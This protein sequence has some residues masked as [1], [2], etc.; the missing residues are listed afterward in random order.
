MRPALP[1]DVVEHG[2]EPAGGGPPGWLRRAAAAVAATAV[3]FAVVRGGLLSADEPSPRPAPTP[4]RATMGT[5]EPQLVARRGDRLVVVRDGTVQRAT[6]L[7]AGLPAD[8]AL[9]TIAGAADAG[10]GPVVGVSSVELFVADPDLGRYRSLGLA[11]ALVGSSPVSGRVYVVR[12]GGIQEVDADTGRTVTRNAFPGYDPEAR[13]EGVL[14]S[15]GDPAVVQA[16]RRGGRVELTL[17]WSRAEVARGA[18]PP[19]QRLGVVDRFLGIAADW[20]LSLDACPGASCRVVV[21]SATRDRVLTRTAEPPPGWRFAPGSSAGSTQEAL[22]PVRAATTG[23]PALA[24][25]VPG[26]QR[27]LLVRGSDGVVLD[28]DLVDGPAGTVWL[29]TAPGA[30]RPP[31][32]RV[33]DPV[34]PNIARPVRPAAA[35]R[36]GDRL[37][38]VCG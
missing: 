24:R 9:T 25:L 10:P 12:S 14:V 37:V 18:R 30:G 23:R 28:A 36:P 32:V 16:R 4:D 31:Q 6:E 34:T 19:V 27:A 7:P 17:L 8:A 29:L 11:D 20:A 5:D 38:C 1:D 35:L 26:G 15:N 33:W 3:L 2:A 21:A 22:V 13:A